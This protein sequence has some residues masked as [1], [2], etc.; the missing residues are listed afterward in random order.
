M[1]VAIDTEC[2]GLNLRHGCKPFFVS[3]CDGDK[4][5]TW[6]WFVDPFTR[7]PKVKSADVLK[8]K[9]ILARA[10]KIVFHNAKFDITA[11]KQIGFSKWDYRKVH[12]TS[13]D[14]HIIDSRA[15]KNLTD[16][17]TRHLELDI[18]PYEKAL[19]EAVEEARDRA[20]KKYPK[21]VLA[22]EGVKSLPSCKEGGQVWR[23]DYWLPNTIAVLEGLN[24]RHPWHSVLDE[25]AACDA[26]VTRILYDHFQEIIRERKLER[27]QAFRQSLIPVA[28]SVEG[29]GITLCDSRLEALKEQFEEENKESVGI[30]QGIARDLDYTL[31]L[32]KTGNNKSLLTLVFRHLQVPI[33]KRSK[34]TSEPSLDKETVYNLLK[35]LKPSTVEYQFIKALADKRN[36]DAALQAIETYRRF[37]LPTEHDDWFMVYSNINPIGTATLRWS[38]S[39]PNQQN[40]SKKEGFGLRDCFGPAP[41]R[42]WWSCDA[43]NI[44]LR[45]PAYESGEQE[46]IDLFERSDEPPYY[47]SNHLLNFHTVY[48]DI[49]DTEIGLVG[50]EKV[51]PHIKK[52]YASTYYQWCKNGGFAV[53]YGAIDVEDGTADKAFKRPGAHKKLKQ[54]FSKLESLNQKWIRFAERYGYVET[55]VDPT[56]DP[57][58]GYPIAIPRKYNGQVKET[59]PLNSHI[60]G[61]SAWWMCKAMK[62][63]I[64]YL[65]TLPGN[66]KLIMQIHDELVFDLPYKPN[67]G[68]KSIML[69]VK[70]LMEQSGRDISIP[71]P[72]GLEYHDSSW[73]KG[74]TIDE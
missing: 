30:M 7:E 22:D 20:E 18:S 43:K 3:L 63:C 64:E 38:S 53:Q 73:G 50:F 33:D 19:E 60:Q 62:R 42:E 15:T 6:S 57:N 29:A 56:I 49:W 24:K 4:T 66:C 23:S 51:G 16:L 5:Y 45:L 52:K 69:R 35:K 59:V 67:L 9:G 1:I 46:L 2:T 61:S 32:P 10:S 12:D 70:S 72:V 26:F 54:R 34:K 44:E 28:I 17:A 11:L 36:R 58:R 48:P 27:I 39:E 68:N 8:I 47:G 14:A 74:T 37:W 21:W 41:G 55:I 40:I 25:Y 13:L 65:A 31:E 71:T